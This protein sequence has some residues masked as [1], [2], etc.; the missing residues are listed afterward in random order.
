MKDNYQYLELDEAAIQQYRDG[1]WVV[2]ELPAFPNG[3][4]VSQHGWDYKKVGNDYLT[5]KSGAADWITASGDAKAAIQN[6][7]NFGNP[8][9]TQQLITPESTALN[10]QPSY[11]NTT[12]DTFRGQP[13]IAQLQQE[14]A[15]ND[16][17]LGPKGVD[18]FNGKFTQGALAAQKQGVSAEE[19]NKRFESQ[20]L[21][22]LP[23]V[24][25]PSTV[26]EN[27]TTG[28]T[29]SRPTSARP[30]AAAERS[31]ARTGIPFKEELSGGWQAPNNPGDLKYYNKDD[32]Y[33][34]DDFSTSPI[35]DISDEIYSHADDFIMDLD[36][37]SPEFKM[38]LKKDQAKAGSCVAG[39]LNCNQKMV[40]NKVGAMSIRGVISQMD[41]QVATNSRYSVP[42]HGG[43]AGMP[44]VGAYKH[45][46]GYDAWELGDA[47]VGEGLAQ[48]LYKVDPNDP[49]FSN[50]K[51]DKY[52]TDFKNSYVDE[53]RIPIGAM[54]FQGNSKE[55]NY[56]DPKYG[57]R[58]SHGTTVVGFSKAGVPLIYDYGKLKEIT[59]PMLSIS[60]VTIPK[61]YE[62]YTYDNLQ[63][64]KRK[65]IENL[66]YNADEIDSPADY[67]S[68]A[69]LEPYV[70]K[71]Y[72]G[73]NEVK[74]KIGVDYN[75]S[76]DVMSK[77]SKRVVGIGG[78]ETN[79]GN[80][81]KED[82]S[83]LRQLAIESESG[84]T[85][86]IAK[87][88]MKGLSNLMELPYAMMQDS[89]PSSMI[90]PDWKV[91]MEAYN[92]VG[93][94]MNKFKAEYN[95]LRD[96]YEKP[97]V[98]DDA[99]A[100]S[101][102]V[103]VFAMKK[104]PDYAKEELGLTKS[105]LYGANVDDDL[106][107]TRG[108]QASLVHMVESYTELKRR[109]KEKLKL[110][111]DDL[112][113]LATVAYNSGGKAYDEDFIKFYIKDKKMPDNYLTKTKKLEEK[114][115]LNS[116]ERIAEINRRQA[117]L[118]AE[119]GKPAWMSPFDSI[120]NEEYKQQ[121]EPTPLP[122]VASES[123]RVARPYV[124]EGLFDKLKPRV[125]PDTRTGDE[126]ARVQ[127]VGNNRKSWYN[128]FDTRKLG[129]AVYK[130]LSKNEIDQY[131]R[132]GW[133]VE[134]AE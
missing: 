24:N 54:V 103:G 8:Q 23:G 88:L 49:A 69:V 67:K 78:K 113:D 63:Q 85:S 74:G 60:R 40:G 133:V 101:S 129:G 18:G 131:R 130:T 4:V 119:E 97:V 117:L 79:F 12:Q 11:Q 72:K 128:P 1:G 19:Y 125:V 39:A 115:A 98:L 47:L 61:G 44:K 2:E 16:Y 102:S 35:L 77:L 94:D 7:V 33:L 80:Y 43:N 81:G 87:P 66:G 118:W 29:E 25:I 83:T 110:T 58:T 9:S 91:E 120:D 73:I 52:T 51:Y 28:S 17:Y 92:N 10:T 112:I 13:D 57:D 109:Y 126:L 31:L 62:N 22:S 111:D 6:R 132:E 45:T 14:L 123:T 26:V 105:K 42:S 116:E 55:S 95:K 104:L 86:S 59:D 134:D 114:Y 56:T 70:N 89:M 3:G 100:N 46:M 41:N 20:E 37:Y 30:S 121:Y 64:G 27:A 48:D 84:F 21:E 75:I 108:A 106:E 34:G 93:G 38:E 90:Q 127:G 50:S 32:K 5:K 124:N 96:M 82:V 122:A 15:D 65:H 76:N 53:G 107:F 99:G 68:D 36:E 71:I